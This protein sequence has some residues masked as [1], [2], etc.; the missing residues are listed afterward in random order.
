[1]TVDQKI[2]IVKRKR[3]QRLF[4]V[5]HGGGGCFRNFLYFLFFLRSTT[6]RVFNFI[7][8]F[9]VFSQN[10]WDV[11]EKKFVWLCFFSFFW[12]E[13]EKWKMDGSFG[14]LRY[15]NRILI[16]KQTK[17]FV[18]FGI[19][20]KYN[21]YIIIII[22]IVI[23]LIFVLTNFIYIY[24]RLMDKSFHFFIIDTYIWFCFIW[25]IRLNCS[26]E[27]IFMHLNLDYLYKKN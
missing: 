10:L 4:K 20:Y 17:T 14:R 8:F 16:I 22:I 13:W 11:R 7:W 15:Y 26:E 9:W 24:I 2:K 19:K 25:G 5:A 6:T 23:I 12:R 21:H 27:Y 3:S 1:M 18:F